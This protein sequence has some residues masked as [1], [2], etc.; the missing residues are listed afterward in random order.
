MILQAIA[1]VLYVFQMI[2]LVRVLLSWFPTID[3]SNPIIQFVYN[4]TEPVLRPIRDLM[5]QTGMMDLSPLIV[6]LIIQV[7]MRL[8]RI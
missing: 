4:V 2:L 7:V 1:L 6:L 8:L 5:P 3:R